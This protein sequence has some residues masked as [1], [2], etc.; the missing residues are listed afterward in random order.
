MCDMIARLTAHSQWLTQPCV[1]R[2]SQSKRALLPN[3]P[4][5]DCGPKYRTFTQPIDSR[6]ICKCW[7][8]SSRARRCAMGLSK[9]QANGPCQT[10]VRRCSGAETEDRD[11]AFA[12]ARSAKIE[13]GA[14]CEYFDS[15]LDIW[16]LRPQHGT[17]KEAPFGEEHALM[18]DCLLSGRDVRQHLPFVGHFNERLPCCKNDQA[19]RQCSRERGRTQQDK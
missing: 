13:R 6:Y 8:R 18:Q 15:V 14:R 10:R 3:R 12:G 11:H 9:R 2:P 7:S 16:G 17:F 19:S 1:H 5:C 4:L